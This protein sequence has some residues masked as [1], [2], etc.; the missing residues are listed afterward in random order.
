MGLWLIQECKRQWQKDGVDLSY[1]E[2]TDMAQKAESFAAHID[3]DYG[4]F[5]SPGDMPTRINNYLAE[6]GQKAID[7]KGQMARVILESLAL[8]Y[9]WVVQRIEDITGKTLDCLHIV[10]GGSRN[11][12]LNQFAANATGKK[13]I[14]GPVEATASGNMLMQAIAAAQIESLARGRELVAASF[15]V[16][17]YQPEDTRLWAEQNIKS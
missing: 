1:A 12:L 11:G 6:T 5:L 17:E 15:D 9:R 4:E 7:D 13:V 2:I 8:K 3:P 10:G 14:A 16:S